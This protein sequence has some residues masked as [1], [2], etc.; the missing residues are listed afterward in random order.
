MV[1]TSG[2]MRVAY[3]GVPP[4]KIPH[5][6]WCY[7]VD[8]KRV[9]IGGALSD[10]GGLYHW[11]RGNLK[12]P[13]DAEAQIAKRVPGAHGLIFMPFLAGERSTG[14]YESAAGAL[15]GLT[16]ATDSIDILQ[17]ALESVAYRFAE[18]FDQLNS[19]VKCD[20]R[21]GMKNPEFQLSS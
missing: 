18:I 7:R 14:Y 19:V 13:K 8:R 21:T 15:L 10:G 5:G 20:V 16:S 2:A 3:R 6:L 17:A 12:L 1:G 11:L 4:K 9:V